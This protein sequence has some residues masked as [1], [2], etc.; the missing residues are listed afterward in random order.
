MLSINIKKG[1]V[2]LDEIL[3][4]QLKWSYLSRRENLPGLENN[5]AMDSSKGVIF[6]VLDFNAFM[7]PTNSLYSA[8]VSFSWTCEKY[9]QN[10]H[11][12]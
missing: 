7:K 8:T 12:N 2:V 3:L 6:I 1:Q 4:R 10:K 5:F 9:Q 11:T